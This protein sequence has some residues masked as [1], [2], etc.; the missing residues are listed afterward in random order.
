M[1][2]IQVTGLTILLVVL[3]VTYGQQSM[4]SKEQLQEMF[5]SISESTDWDMSGD[6]LWGYFFADADKAILERVAP[7]LE[8]MGYSVN[9]IFLSDTEFEDEPDLWWLHVE[10]IE[11]HSVDSLD[12]TN[13]AFYEFAEKHGL[14]T[15][16]G[17]DVGPVAHAD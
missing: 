8:E 3:Q 6:M 9:S 13:L 12:K 17:M 7:I 1:K 4:I 15:Y 16:D 5:D 14:D 10:K 2:F 11:T